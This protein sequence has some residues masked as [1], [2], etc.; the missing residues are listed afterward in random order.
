MDN[1]NHFNVNLVVSTKYNFGFEI[2]IQ[3][4]MP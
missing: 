3:Q 4:I 1:K 2:F